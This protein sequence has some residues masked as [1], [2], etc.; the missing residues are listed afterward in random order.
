MSAQKV[1]WAGYMPVLEVMLTQEKAI[2]L[3]Q[4][5]RAMGTPIYLS[6]LALDFILWPTWVGDS[7]VP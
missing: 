3:L 6:M 4:Q 1:T 7:L 2:S 5:A